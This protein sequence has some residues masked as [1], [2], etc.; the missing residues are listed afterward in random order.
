MDDSARGSGWVGSESL[1]EHT[2]RVGSKS[3]RE[4]RRCGRRDACGIDYEVDYYSA[5]KNVDV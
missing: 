5:A 2:G 3:C 1:Q 4:V